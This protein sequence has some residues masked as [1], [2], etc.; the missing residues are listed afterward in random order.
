MADNYDSPGKARF[1]EILEVLPPDLLQKYRTNPAAANE[2]GAPVIADF[3][4]KRG[5][6]V[7]PDNHPAIAEAILHYLDTDGSGQDHWVSAL[8]GAAGAIVPALVGGGN[9]GGDQQAGRFQQLQMQLQQEREAAKR[10]QQNML[11]IGGA[12]VAVV[13][14]IFLMKK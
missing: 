10:R 2:E 4:N 14:I 12:V 5:Y 13:L 7:S 6:N 11:L 9:Q 1:E 8:I 3:L